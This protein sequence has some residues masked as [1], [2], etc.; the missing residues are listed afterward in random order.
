MASISITEDDFTVLAAA[1]HEALQRGD[2]EDA[3]KLDKIARKM[4]ASLGNAS[5]AGVPKRPGVKGLTWQDVP[6]TL[7]I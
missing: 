7:G 4:N 1:A 5:M 6:S 2:V 3:M